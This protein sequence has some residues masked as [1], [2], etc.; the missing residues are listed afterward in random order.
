MSRLLIPE[1]VAR[2]L[3]RSAVRLVCCYA[4]LQCSRPLFESHTLAA[5]PVGMNWQ[6]VPQLSD[7]FNVRHVNPTGDGLDASKWWDFHPTW[8]GRLPSQF[9]ADNT[10]IGDG[11]LNLRSTA[12]V[13]DMSEVS[14]LATDHWVDSAVITSRSEAQP[15]DY[16]E[17]SI[18]TAGLSMTSSWWFRQGA[19][20]EIDVIEN[21]GLPTLPRS[22]SPFRESVMA[23]NTHFFDP[24]T[25]RDEGGEAQMFDDLSNPLLSREQFVTYG[26]WWKSPT[27][28]RFYYN[29]NE[30][31]TVTPKGLFDEGLNMFFDM[32]VFS[33]V[34][35]PTLESLNDPTKNTM[36][37]DWVRAYRPVTNAAPLD[38]LVDNP[39]FELS[40]PAEPSR[41]DLW[42]DCGKYDGCGGVTPFETRSDETAAYSG[43]W[44][45]KIDNEQP[46]SFGQYKEIGT[47]DSVYSFLAGQTVRQKVRVK[48]TE[49]WAAED[50]TFVI[51]LRLNG[52]PGQAI[53]HQFV[54]ND[55]FGGDQLDE[56]VTIEFDLEIPET[57]P[58]GDPVD[59]VTS[60]SYVD[61]RSTTAPLDGT[62]FLDDFSLSVV[63]AVLPG[64]F[65]G[66]GLVNAADVDAL[67]TAVRLGAGGALFDLNNDGQVTFEIN[68]PG[69]SDSD[70]LIR[71]I[72]GTEYGDANLDGKVDITDLDL[73]GQS[74]G[75]ESGWL[76]GDFNGSA[77]RT[78]VI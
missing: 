76:F 74:Y 38:N 77:T 64:D 35:F 19:K 61:N 12:L 31:A 78:L 25:N 44:S 18:K 21:I 27:E 40:H 37:V 33:W 26:V 56:W 15:G 55:E 9:S 65:D 29:G 58:N 11:K 45:L 73:L 75:A 57:A 42:A 68:A 17:A 66:N 72:L 13:S 47:R 36:Q 7:E 5:P 1:L 23:Y 24:G 14:N 62:L 22:E 16:F 28:I 3:S 51:G 39:S 69:G 67:A 70:Y 4:I 71:T 53:T 54:I 32:E 50:G 20:S 46:N 34:G 10:W 41:P 48:L 2:T 43:D 63:D 52:D 6:Y 49:L 8:E 60:I 59:Y 30:A